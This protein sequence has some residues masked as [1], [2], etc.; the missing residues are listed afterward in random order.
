M[1]RYLCINNEM[2][3]DLMDMDLRL[4]RCTDGYKM[5]L[6]SNIKTI[7]VLRYAPA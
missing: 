2:S 1:S 6:Y 3:Q 5:L 4:Y 7:W